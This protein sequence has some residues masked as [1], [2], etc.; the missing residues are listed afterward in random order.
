[1]IR[2]G[3]V[4]S[5]QR[6]ARELADSGAPHGT[7]V[8]AEAQSQGRGRQGRRWESPPGDNLLLSVVLRPP[9]PL[10]EAPLLSLGAAAGLAVAFGLRVKWPNDLVV[11]DGRKVGGLLA[12][13]ETAGGRIAY[14]V[15]GLGLNV[16]AAP[17]EL[18]AASLAQLGAEGRLDVSPWLAGDRL[19]V[20][21]VA[22]DALRA[23]LAWSSHPARLDT[24]RQRSHTLGRRVRVAGREGVATA[25]R[26]DG[27]LLVD[28]EPVLAGDVELVQPPL[29]AAR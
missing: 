22:D 18:P 14:V 7:A 1:M 8:R 9:G 17:P 16:N 19:D 12:E 2:V 10:H 20:E 15:L 26:D 28:G 29:T 6:V 4:D 13:L 3:V 11:P 25:L 23:I 24:W 21:A 27:A 5:T